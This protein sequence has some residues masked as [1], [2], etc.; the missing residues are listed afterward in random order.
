MKN[1]MNIGGVE[2]LRRIMISIIVFIIGVFWFGGLVQV[3]L[4]ILSAILFL[5]GISGFCP[6]YTL[7]KIQRYKK[8]SKI[9]KICWIIFTIVFL[10]VTVG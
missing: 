8:D 3:S 7:F 5:T 10:L 6:L 4:F 2:R 9:P 1:L